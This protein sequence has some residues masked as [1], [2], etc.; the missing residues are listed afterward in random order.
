MTRRNQYWLDIEHQGLGKFRRVQG[1]DKYVVERTAHEQ[2]K[3]WK[4]LWARR[5]AADTARSE[6][7]KHIFT[8]DQR[9]SEAAVRTSEAQVAAK[10][11]VSILENRMRASVITDVESLHDKGTFDQPAP[12]RPGPEID[13]PGPTFDAS[14]Y[15]PVHDFWSFLPFV[16]NRRDAA[17]QERERLALAHHLERTQ[18]WSTYDCELATWLQNKGRFEEEIRKND[19]AIDAL[20]ARCR[21]GDGDAIAEWTNVALARSQYP[22]GFPQTWD[23]D[24]VSETG[25][26]IIDYELPNTSAVPSIKAV[27]YIQSRDVSEESNFRE[28]EIEDMYEEAIY[29]TCLRT[30]H[31]IFASDFSNAI[32]IVTFNGWVD[33]LDKTNGNPARACILSVQSTREKFREINLSAVEPK[34]CFRALKGVGSAKLAGMASVVPILR[35]NRTDPRFVTPHD[36]IST[37]EET[38]NIAAIPWEEFEFLVRDLFEKEFSSDGSEVKITRASRDRGVDAIAFDSDPIRGG[39]IVIQ[40][41]R[42]TNT[43]DVS[44]VRDLFGTVMAEGANRGILVTTSRYGPDAYDFAK[45]KPITLL[46]GGNLLSLLEKHGHRARIDLAEAKKIAAEQERL[47]R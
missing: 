42:Y 15:A 6:R 13:R 37:V 21:A 17:A 1:S 33:F 47:G 24:F 38:T 40:A 2:L 45:D 28:S 20:R 23:L 44:A 19:A 39:K 36:A 4:E 9:K 46:D 35:L 7:Q 10:A 34:A 27:K 11:F 32:K 3:I 43:V 26:M 18:A 8:R 14:P 5:S 25:V 30:L 41:K 31:E 12:K 29:Q 16:R 22:A